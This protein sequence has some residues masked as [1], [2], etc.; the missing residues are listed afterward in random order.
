MGPSGMRNRWP[1]LVALAVLLAVGGGVLAI[2]I[3]TGDDSSDEYAAAKDDLAR[4][5]DNLAR[6][7]RPAQSNPDAARAEQIDEL[8]RRTRALEDRLAE[9]DV[10][11][12]LEAEASRV[13]A[14]V[15][16]LI[17]DLAALLD[18]V[19][20]G[21][22]TAIT[23]AS[24]R[25]VV[26]AGGGGDG[27][28]PGPP[29][30]LRV[31]QST[32]L[33]TGSRPEDAGAGCA[34]TPCVLRVTLVKVVDPVK[35]DPAYGL[36][37]PGDPARGD[38]GVGFVLR[39]ANVGRNPYDQ[40]PSNDL[41]LEPFGPEYESE[42]GNAE[43]DTSR[44]ADPPKKLAPGA[45]RIVCVVVTVGKGE[46]LTGARYRLQAQQGGRIVRWSLSS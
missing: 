17:A 12:E 7:L 30:R 42:Y 14:D 28:G 37:G 19:R 23:R 25:I 39:L 20:A 6:Q 13:R 26:R 10:P 44:D 32:T 45:S 8:L 4:L 33:S 22:A 41:T 9:A 36:P 46:K 35:P 40:Y 21:E 27:G 1:F 24:R 18:A 2:V 34:R 29:G 16:R 43:C 38:R 31:G 11:E 15:D 3:D 5:K